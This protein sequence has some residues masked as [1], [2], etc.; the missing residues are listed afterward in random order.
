MRKA[1]KAQPL[2]TAESIENR[3]AGFIEASTIRVRLPQ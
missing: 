1:A 3:A 2:L